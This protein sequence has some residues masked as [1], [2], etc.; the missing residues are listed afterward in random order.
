MTTNLKSLPGDFSGRVQIN[1]TYIYT[2]I[3]IYIFSTDS[4]T[5]NTR[6]SNLGCLKISL[7][8][9]KIYGRQSVNISAIY[10]WNYLQSYH[11]NIV[12]NQLS[13]TRLKK[14]IMQYYFSNYD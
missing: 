10:T 3:Y 2:Y 6:W 11:R 8:K 1:F 14:L 4:H 9:T 13:L 7:Y 12:F 5:H